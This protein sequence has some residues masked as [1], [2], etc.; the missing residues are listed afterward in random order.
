MKIVILIFIVFVCFA[1]VGVIN[2]IEKRRKRKL[3][4]RESSPA[5][6]PVESGAI[7][8]PESPNDFNERCRNTDIQRWREQGFVLGYK[9]QRSK[10]CDANCEVCR[11]G[12]GVYPLSFDW[13][14]WHDKCVCFITPIT[15]EADMYAELMSRDNWKHEMRAYVDKHRIADVPDVFKSWVV[16]HQNEIADKIKTDELNDF[17]TNNAHIIFGKPNKSKQNQ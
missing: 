3:S 14:G 9:I 16:Q 4:Q 15:I 8:S 11:I 7:D 17:V 6:V 12:E 13:C 10:N 5:H 1:L 2:D